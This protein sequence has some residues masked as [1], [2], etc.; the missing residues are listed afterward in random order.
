VL[1]VLGRISINNRSKEYKPDL[2][3]KYL[4]LGNLRGKR[5][6]TGQEDHPF[7][8]ETRSGGINQSG[9][10]LKVSRMGGGGG[11]GGW[12]GGFFGGGGGVFLFLWL[13][14]CGFLEGGVG[15]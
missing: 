6:K 1:V 7:G 15:F 11:G 8:R 2:S 13:G 14:W 12:G 5:E 10:F 3:L 4:Y 9:D